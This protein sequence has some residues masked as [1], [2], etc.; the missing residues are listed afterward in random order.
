MGI[1]ILIGDVRERLKGLPDESV[2]CCVTS[3]PYYGLRD[4]GVAGQIGLEPSPD[5]YVAEL[6]AVFREVRRV[7][8]KDATLWLNLGDSYAG[9]WG[10]Q[11]RPDGN[12]VRSALEGGSMLSARQI[13]AHP[14]GTLTGSLKNTPGLKA[15]D[16]MMI[17]ARVALALQADGWWLRS[18][19]IWHKPNPMPESV[20]DRPTSAH[21]HVFL[22]AKSERYYF[23]A[24]AV[25]EAVSESFIERWGTAAPPRKN[26]SP[27]G[28]IAG[29]VSGESCMGANP[30]GRNI[31]NVWTVATQPY[32][33]AHFATFPPDLIEPCIKAG[34]PPLGT[35]LDPFG[36]AG[37]TGLVADRLQ[38]SAILIEL[39]PAYAEVARKRLQGDG[40][41]FAEVQSA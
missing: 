9:S 33:E 27:Q 11:S 3:P 1:S 31:R 5:A 16:L 22:L 10:A 39:N 29:S 28:L 32:S 6:V 37:T 26:V 41:M 2:H 15:K 17:P 25:R 4:Y 24:D 21:E 30:L 36:G 18:D 8:R 34:C 13:A 38:R 7:M 12:D 14:K 40:G 20:T 19:I 35:V 23:N